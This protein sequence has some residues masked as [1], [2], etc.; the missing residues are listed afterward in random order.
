[1]KKITFTYEGVEITDPTMDESGRFE[2]N[3]IE[4]YEEPYIT[5]WQD[6]IVIELQ[7]LIDEEIV[8]NFCLEDTS[9]GNDLCRSL[10]IFKGDSSIQIFTPNHPNADEENEQFN[11]YSVFFEDGNGNLSNSLE[12]ES[13]LTYVIDMIQNLMTQ[14]K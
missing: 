8:G 9:W 5:A 10:T 14:L 3:P 2:V 4:Y 13:N 11:T 7:N 12:G 1:M 6:A